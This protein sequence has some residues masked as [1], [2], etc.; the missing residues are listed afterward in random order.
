MSSLC[1]GAGSAAKASQPRLSPPQSACKTCL[2][3]T[4]CLVCDSLKAEHSH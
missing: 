2:P 3:F 4:Q 1:E